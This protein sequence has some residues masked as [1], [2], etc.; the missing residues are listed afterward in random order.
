MRYAPLPLRHAILRLLEHEVGPGH[1]S[2]YDLAAASGRLLDQL[3][4]RLS[5]IIGPAGVEAIFLRIVKIR[6]AEFPFLDGPFTLKRESI[7]QAL[8]A[9]LQ[10]LEPDIIRS[11]A[12][13][14]IATFAGVL[15]TVIGEGLA[16]S[17]IRDV[18]PDTLPEIEPQ[19]ANE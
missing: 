8:R 2:S 5:Q 4:Q 12:G 3:S 16:W 1:A 14:L 6:R 10:E 7:G 9:R 15:A 17:L 13:T 11:A 18:W 19:E